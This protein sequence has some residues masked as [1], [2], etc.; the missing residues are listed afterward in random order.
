MATKEYSL[1]YGKGYVKFSLDPALVTGELKIKTAPVLPDPAAA[2]REAIRSPIASQP[3]REVVKPGETVALIV[4]DPTRVANSHV[5]MP[6]LL[7]ELNAAGVP[8]KD[9]FVI[10]ALGTHRDMTPEEMAEAVG[11]AVAKRVR[12]FNSNAK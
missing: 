7:D 4:N 12:M 6:I 2:I 5:F 3:L 8:D 9:M 1:K 10:F 11:P